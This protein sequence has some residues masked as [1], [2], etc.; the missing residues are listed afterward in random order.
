MTAPRLSAMTLAEF[1]KA[2]LDEDEVIAKAA[3]KIGREEAASLVGH[4]HWAA[5]YG[6]VVDADDDDFAMMY[7]SV[8]N[9]T[10]EVCDH[11]ARHDPARALR[12]VEAKRMIL[13]FWEAQDAEE[14][15]REE[16]YG[17]FLYLIVSA[18]AAIWCGHPDYQQAW[19]P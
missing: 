1:L 14:R 10:A 13:T 12:E 19:K 6:T 16:D 5:R 2:R 3:A 15:Q 8:T 7:S 9:S 4:A 18:A 11:I 17:G